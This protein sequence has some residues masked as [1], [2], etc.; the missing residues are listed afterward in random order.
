MVDNSY[1]HLFIGCEKYRHGEK[2]HTFIRLAHQHPAAVFQVWGKDR[3]QIHEDLLTEFD[4]DESTSIKYI[5][6]MILMFRYDKTRVSRR[7]FK[8]TGRQE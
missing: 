1:N 7:L 5:F 4:I 2:G 6:G 3:C 8:C